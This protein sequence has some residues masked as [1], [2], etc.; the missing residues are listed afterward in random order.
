MTSNLISFTAI[1]S[2]LGHEPCDLNAYLVTIRHPVLRTFSH[3]AA[4]PPRKLRLEKENIPVF[5]QLLEKYTVP[6]SSAASLTGDLH[7][8]LYRPALFDNFF[9]R[10]LLDEADFRLPFAK[11]TEAHLQTAKRRL[12]KMQLVVPAANCTF[13]VRLLMVKMLGWPPDV[14]EMWGSKT[15]CT[16]E[17]LH[18]LAPTSM[19]R[20][21]MLEERMSRERARGK[22]RLLFFMENRVLKHS[23]YDI[24]LFEFGNALFEQRFRSFFS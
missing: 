10:T 14:A 13:E 21:E 12:A 19:P 17:L 6:S 5:K 24:A 18:G 8:A 1:E 20:C 16:C 22:Y 11:I 2:M 15:P 23:K 7:T 4:N 3:L 9:V